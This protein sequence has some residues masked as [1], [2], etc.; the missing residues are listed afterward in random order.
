MHV[1]S[2][3]VRAVGLSDEAGAARPQNAPLSQ[4]KLHDDDAQTC[5]KI[6]R[7]NNGRSRCTRDGWSHS[8]QTSRTVQISVPA[9]LKPLISTKHQAP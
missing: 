2:L 6:E 1:R 3:E 5:W 8:E 4:P 9:E 7:T